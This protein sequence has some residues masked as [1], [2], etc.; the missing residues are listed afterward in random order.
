MDFPP[1]IESD[2]PQRFVCGL[3]QVDARMLDVRSRPA[4]SGLR[5]RASFLRGG[6]GGASPLGALLRSL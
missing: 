5:W 6:I 2:L 3:W 1:L 4:A